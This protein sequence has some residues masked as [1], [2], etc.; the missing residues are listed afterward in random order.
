MSYQELDKV[1]FRFPFVSKDEPSRE[2][3]YKKIMPTESVTQGEVMETVR[4][5][6]K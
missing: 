6:P 1:H 4:G 3:W 2:G 5:P